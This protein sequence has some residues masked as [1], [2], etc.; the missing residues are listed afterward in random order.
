LDLTEE[1]RAFLIGRY[2]RPQPRTELVIPVRN[3]AQGAIDVS[4]GLVADVDKLARVSR[5]G[6]VIET[7][8]VPFSPAAQKA[9]AREPALLASLLTA[10]DDYEIV[11]AVPETS[12]ASFEAEA[13]NK[14]ATVTAIGQI[15]EPNGEVRV[16]GPDGEPLA[17]ERKGYAHF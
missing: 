2:R 13:S 1:D 12:A 15:A 3:F 10:G 11:A 4:D 8:K 7:D 14:G 9:L 17:L 16:L 5:V 6:A